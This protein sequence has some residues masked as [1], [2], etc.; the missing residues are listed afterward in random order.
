M[1]LTKENLLLRREELLNDLKNANGTI[2]GI[3]DDLYKV[4]T[5]LYKT[6]DYGDNPDN[7][8]VITQTT[9]NNS[10]PATFI[11]DFR[12]INNVYSFGAFSLYCLSSAALMGYSIYTGDPIATG[13]SSGLFGVPMLSAALSKGIQFLKKVFKLG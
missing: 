13:I 2:A 5:I 9:T 1:E 12:L 7:N 6:Y 11:D 8:L 10:N 3:E 4:D